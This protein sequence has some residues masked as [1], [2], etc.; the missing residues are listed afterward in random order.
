MLSVLP[1]CRGAS[2]Q[3]K[4]LPAA[5]VSGAPEGAA[6]PFPCQ[7]VIGEL[8]RFPGN[9]SVPYIQV[10]QPSLLWLALQGS[11]EA[12]LFPVLFLLTSTLLCL[13]SQAV[14]KMIDQVL[15]K[16]EESPFQMTNYASKTSGE[17]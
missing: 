17:L 2:Q 3:E 5:S 12:T 11:W 1:V 8:W 15:E 13:S 16:L 4:P 7:M 10:E 14:Q 6:S 9:S